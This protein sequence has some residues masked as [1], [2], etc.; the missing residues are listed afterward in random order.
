V[1]AVLTFAAD[2]AVA[3]E[4]ALGAKSLAMGRTGTAAYRDNVAVRLN[5]GLMPLTNRYDFEGSFMFGPDGGLHWMGSAVDARTSDLLAAGI[6]YYGQRYHP[7]PTE[8]E[9]PG[10]VPTDGEITNVKWEHDFVVSAAMPLFDR[11]LGFGMTFAPA[12]HDEELTGTG[13]T[14]DMHAGIGVHPVDWLTVGA[15]T[16]NVLPWGPQYGDTEISG[17][18]LIDADPVAVET[19]IRYRPVIDTFPQLAAGTAVWAGEVQIRG[20]WRLDD[21][22]TSWVS[23]GI[24]FGE[25]EGASIAYGMALPLGDH[26]GHS[27]EHSMHEVTLRM[28]AQAPIPDV[29]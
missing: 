5:P 12:Y 23:T 3:Q 21:A 14:F 26:I 8:E 20:G 2:L 7:P 15:A 17:G 6:G 27:L 16:R 18:I 1:F 11:R 10:W 29:Y 4:P 25:T 13:W 9:L 22:Q 19:D 28:G 24:A